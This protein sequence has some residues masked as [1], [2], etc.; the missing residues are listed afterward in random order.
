M[1]SSVRHIHCVLIFTIT[2]AAITAN[3][4]QAAVTI[5]SVSSGIIRSSV[6]VPVTAASG[7]KGKGNQGV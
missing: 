7:R 2:T 4:L 6:A 3:L 5:A 1:S